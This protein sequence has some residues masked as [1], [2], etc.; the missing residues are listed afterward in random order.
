MTAPAFRV[1]LLGDSILDNGAYTRGEPDVA[2]HLRQLLPAGSIVTLAAV[3]G[4]TTSRLHAQLRSVPADASHVVVAI[5][6]N[7]A[8]G[9]IDLL[10]LPVRSTAEALTLFADRV[11][12][13]EHAYT[14]A[15]D[16]VLDLG[17]S[18][19]ICTVYN[20]ALEAARARVARV[21]L[22]LFNDVIVRTAT[23][24]RADL[25]ELR[26]ICV[27]PGDYA[28]PIEPSGSGGSKIA[29]AIAH[30]IGANAPAAA[31]SQVWTE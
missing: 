27:E 21:A 1:V 14:T 10:G 19:V 9:N 5:G 12:T 28:N 30:A 17:R 23:S 31:P 4:A 15:I 24:R 20:G 3:D 6:G 7:D 25:I 16:A 11:D 26:A 22:T 29:R 18:T 13:F 2:A 8:L